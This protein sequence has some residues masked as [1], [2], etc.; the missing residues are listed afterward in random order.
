MENEKVKLMSACLL[1]VCCRYDGKSKLS[2]KAVEI[3]KKGN[4]ILV[5]PEQLGGLATPRASAEIQDDGRV[6][7]K[8]G[9]DVTKSFKKGAEETLKIAKMI[10]AEEFIVKS[11]SPSCGFGKIYDGTFSGNL[12]DGKGITSDLLNKNNIKITTEEDI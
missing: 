12:I 7:N 5:C 8:E 11:K 6:L 3:F 2:K 9:E 4:V 10:N 1:G